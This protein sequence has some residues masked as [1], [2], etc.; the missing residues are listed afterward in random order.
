MKKR[1]MIFDLDGTLLDTLKDIAISVNYVLSI[2][3]KKPILLDDFRYLVGEGALKLMQ[4]ALRVDEKEARKALVLFEKHYANQYAQNT[5]LYEGIG[6]LLTFLKK[7]GFK[8]AIL[9][10]KPDS[11]TKLCG[12]KYLRDWNFDAVYGIRE[13]VSRKPDAAG[14]FEIL[15]ELHIEPG[16]CL[17]M[18][19][20]K[21]DMMTAKNADIDSIGVLW[22]FRDKVELEENGA[23]YIVKTPVE[24][25]KLIESLEESI[26]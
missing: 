14:A 8:M 10:N 26:D 13:G 4:D 5:K 21:I 12:I 11:F 16:E 1:A 7:K 15:K 25:V 9:S 19:D 6:K 18:G 2:Y 22:G 24:A 3:N 17:F 23:K 20:T